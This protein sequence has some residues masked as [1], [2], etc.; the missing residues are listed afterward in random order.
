M[1]K[2]RLFR[3]LKTPDFRLFSA[4]EGARQRRIWKRL[5]QA[6]AKEDFSYPASLDG[7]LRWLEKSLRLGRQYFTDRKDIASAYAK[8][9]GGALV[10]L[11]VPV[12]E[13]LKLFALE[14]QN[15]G[16]R[17]NKLEL[18]YVVSGTVLAKRAKAWRLKVT[19]KQ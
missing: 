19:R 6:R 16:S 17:K 12:A 10:T 11:E 14:F 3:G 18:V 2:I 15:F 5:L 13:L 9:N 4:A 7:D 1:P 8:A